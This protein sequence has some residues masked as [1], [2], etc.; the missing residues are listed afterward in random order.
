[1][2][3]RKSTLLSEVEFYNVMGEGKLIESFNQRG[4][5]DSR[6]FRVF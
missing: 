6:R 4:D 2:L 1:M 5:E 3:S